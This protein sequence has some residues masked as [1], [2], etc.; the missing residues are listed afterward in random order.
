MSTKHI[1]I[2]IGLVLVTIAKSNAQNV[3][4]GLLGGYDIVNIYQT[5]LPPHAIGPP[6]DPM[7]SYNF[8]FLIS[9]KSK[10]I[11]GFS[12]EPGLIQKGG[13]LGVQNSC[14]AELNYINMPILADIYVLRKLFFSFGPEFAYMI[15]A[16][17]DY[18]DSIEDI[19]SI[20][21]EKFELSGLIAT[22]YMISNKIAIG[23]RYNHGLTSIRKVPLYGDNW[24]ILG[25]GK[26]YNRYF[27]FNVRFSF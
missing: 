16:K 5:S 27:Q 4:F 1:S 12:V 23:L 8:N 18:P 13:S 21:K 15:N 7:M 11:W 20:Y 3:K 9:M 26:Q 17:A 14:R 24:E 19:S 2:V 25:I 6:Y 22:N 10:G